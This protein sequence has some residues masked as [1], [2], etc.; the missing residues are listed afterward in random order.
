M[1]S[2][3]FQEDLSGCPVCIPLDPRFRFAHEPTK[4]MAN[5][6]FCGRQEELKDLTLRMLFSD[7]GAF[8]ITG[9]RGVG[10]TSF[11]NEVLFRLQ[12][13]LEWATPQLGPT[14][15]VDVAL[16]LPRRVEPN[17]LMHY[18]VRQLHDR[19]SN[20]GILGR[21]PAE[22]QGDL[23][24]AYR[25]TSFA[26]T[27]KQSS[28][29]DISVGKEVGWGF[30]KAAIKFPFEVKKS[31]SLIQEASFL[32]YD[33]KSAERDIIRLSRDIARG[34][35]LPENVLA[36]LWRKLRRQTRPHV[37][38]KLLFIFD[39]LDKLELDAPSET[40][41]PEGDGNAA[42]PKYSSISHSSLDSIL[43]TL[44]TL[45]TTS[46]MTFVFVAGKDL[47]DRWLEDVGRGDSVWSEPQN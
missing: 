29:L 45:F 35:L 1:K 13:A 46:G 33:E 14:Q 26:M 23:V 25:R 47:Y 9:Y 36:R 8:L 20:L 12:Y 3:P 7:G 41:P 30:A 11:I 2:S 6:R 17:E 39:E 4:P 18:I 37:R 16:S 44:K 40:I 32:G 34:Y 24:E 5:S 10:K 28:G 31:R 22:V 38:L 15:L 19:L 21:L 27:R 42:P 43:R